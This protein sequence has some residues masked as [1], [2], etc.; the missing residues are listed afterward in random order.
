MD[1][2]RGVSLSRSDASDHQMVSPIAAVA[3]LRIMSGEG[4]S[5]Y[6]HVVPALS[7]FISTDNSHPLKTPTEID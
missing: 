2:I 3:L 6:I 4:E 1:E 5:G 7:I